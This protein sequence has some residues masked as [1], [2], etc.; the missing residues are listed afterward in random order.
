MTA[1]KPPGPFELCAPLQRQR[2]LQRLGPDL[3]A[4]GSVRRSCSHINFRGTMKFNVERTTPG[5]PWMG[6]AATGASAAAC[7]VAQEFIDRLFFRLL[8]VWA[9]Q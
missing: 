4:I 9:M 1:K 8:F 5:G 7:R 6:A 3:A 2:G